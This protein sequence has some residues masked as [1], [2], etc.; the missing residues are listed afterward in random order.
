MMMDCPKCG[1]N[2]PKDQYCANCGIDVEK[3]LKEKPH[4]LKNFLSSPKTQITGIVIAIFLLVTFVYISQQNKLNLQPQTPE[5][6]SH[7]AAVNQQENKQKTFLSSKRKLK[8]ANSP[9]TSPKRS[10]ITPASN[11]PKKPNT[12]NTSKEAQKGL[13]EEN[14]FSLSI[15]FAT[16]STVQLAQILREHSK[17]PSQ[18]T[19]PIKDI[20]L[21]SVFIFSDYTKTSRSSSN[22]QIKDS[23]FIEYFS[24]EPSEHPYGLTVH[25]EANHKT[26]KISGQLLF[27]N[28]K[29]EPQEK[30]FSLS[31]PTPPLES[32]TLIHHLLSSIQLQEPQPPSSPLSVFNPLPQEE[33]SAEEQGAEFLILIKRVD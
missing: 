21:S 33:G 7:I 6:P 17:D 2:Q 30:R 1:F 11:I 9:K 15:S 18:P 29:R 22:N 26:T 8:K 13:F 14:P 27:P 10:A 24:E 12:S 4:K 3:Y 16:A 19:I 23:T 20:P 25:I 28:K 5:N 31:L 32:A